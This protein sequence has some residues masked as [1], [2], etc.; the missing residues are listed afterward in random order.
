M[1]TTTKVLPEKIENHTHIQDFC[2]LFGQEH[3]TEE[4]IKRQHELWGFSLY[5]LHSQSLIEALKL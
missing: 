4:T 5:L 3:P 2:D 1:T